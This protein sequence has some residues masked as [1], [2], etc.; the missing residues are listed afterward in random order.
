M[1][2]ITLINQKPLYFV[3]LTQQNAL[4]CT[5]IIKKPPEGG[6]FGVLTNGQLTLAVN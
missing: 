6:F 5:K 1:V 4:A 2:K 3:A